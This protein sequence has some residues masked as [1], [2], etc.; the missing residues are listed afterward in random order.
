MCLAAFVYIFVEIPHEDYIIVYRLPC[1]QLGI[2]I[3][4][5]YPLWG[6]SITESTKISRMLIFHGGPSGPTR[7]AGL[8]GHKDLH[9]LG[10]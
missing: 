7:V 5:E 6:W 2:E 1:D 8:V 9:L 10:S 4:V 3:F